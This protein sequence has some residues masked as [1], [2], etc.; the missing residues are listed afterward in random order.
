MRLNSRQAG[1][2]TFRAAARARFAA[3]PDLSRPGMD[4]G[5]PLTAREFLAAEG[6]SDPDAIEAVLTGQVG[7]RFVPGDGTASLPLHLRCL[8]VCLTA[9]SSERETLVEA[10]SRA[11]GGP[12]ADPKLREMCDPQIERCWLEVREILSRHDRYRTG[13]LALAERARARGQLVT[14]GLHWLRREDPVLWQAICDLGRPTCHP[15][16]LAL[17]CHF[18]TEVEFGRPME[19]DM[20]SATRTMVAETDPM[21]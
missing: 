20:S 17:L 21:R 5:K 3:M 2:K 14:A 18:R 19:V 12:D 15:V 13:M 9:R 1:A 10:V 4:P 11:W 7:P 8:V 6:A 16:S